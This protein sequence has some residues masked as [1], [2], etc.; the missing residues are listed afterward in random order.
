MT[1][2]S[3]IFRKF[4]KDDRGM[5]SIEFALFFPFYMGMFLW[6]AE[7]GIITIKS[8]MLDHAMDVTIRELRLGF[9]PEPTAEGL[10]EDICARARIINRCEDQLM[11]EL[12]AVSTQTW[13]MPQTPVTCVDNDEEIQPV[14]TFAPGRPQELMLV[15]ACIIVPVIFPFATFGRQLTL[16]GSGGIGLSSISSFV[17]E[18]S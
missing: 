16:D 18:P 10:K 14:V 4:R 13:A 3:K 12:Q 11:L 1:L 8:V 5:A 15:R 7:L 17:N 2:F 9:I 6:A